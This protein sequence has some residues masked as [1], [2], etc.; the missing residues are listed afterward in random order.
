MLYAYHKFGT[1]TFTDSLKDDYK[2]ESEKALS[3][4]DYAHKY[5]KSENPN[6]KRSLSAA[7]IKQYINNISR[8]NSLQVGREN[9]ESKKGSSIMNQKSINSRSNDKSISI[10]SDLGEDNELLKG[11]SFSF[12]S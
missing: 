8:Q 6:I 5:D 9:E 11:K 2:Q 7:A 1:N 4:S 3:L 12:D 10:N